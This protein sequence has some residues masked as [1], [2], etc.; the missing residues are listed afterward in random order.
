MKFWILLLSLPTLVWAYTPTSQNDCSALDL[1]NSNLDQVRDQKQMAWCYAFTGADLLADTFDTDERISAADVAI[2]Y[3]QTKLGLL[4]RWLNLNLINRRKPNI[5]VLAHQTGF[6]KISLERAMS[7]GWCPERVFPSE[8]W[9]KMTR[10]S[11][12]WQESQVDLDKAMI[13]IG[14]LHDVR[15]NLTSDNL[16]FYYKF[17]NVDAGQ[18]VK[19]LQTKNIARFYADLRENVCRDDRK[20]FNTEW[21]VKMVLKNPNLFKRVSEQLELGRLVGL[22]YNSR[23]L[24]DSSNRGVTF[25]GLHTSSI[26]GRRWNGQKNS[27]EFLIRD[28]HGEECGEKYDPSYE[29]DAGN[30]WIPET[31]IYPSTVS[32]VYM[33]SN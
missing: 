8:S 3:N 22:D 24:Q 11:H 29:C 27:C 18:F 13:E 30:V 1:R 21:K 12:G 2:G 14:A 28:S 4:V 15:K 23:I 6:N 26:V 33:L 31:K 7:E 9:T 25:A 17:K 32:I 20:P 16:P 10:T 19:M 5:A